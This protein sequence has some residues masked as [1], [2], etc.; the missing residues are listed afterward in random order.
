[1]GSKVCHHTP[2]QW[3]AACPPYPTWDALTQD[4]GALGVS[5]REPL[6]RV[7]PSQLRRAASSLEKRTY[8]TKQELKKNH[9]CPL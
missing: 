6:V 8:K 2:G 1:M 9:S 4:C 7:K 5:G 3:R